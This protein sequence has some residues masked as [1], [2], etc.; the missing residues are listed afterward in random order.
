MENFVVPSEDLSNKECP[1]A[2]IKCVDFRFRKSDQEF[3][4]EGLGFKDFDM[5]AW[6]GSAKEVLKDNG[7]KKSLVEK[8]VAVSK[9]LHNVKKVLLLW[10]CDNSEESCQKNLQT[11]KDLLTKDLP[12]DMEIILAYS[13]I[14]PQGL[15]YI[16]LE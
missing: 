9:N 14:S 15:E 8:V 3:V 16:V 11:A 1:L 12:A 2:V 13:K 6:P 5:Y 7:F 10:H 4:E